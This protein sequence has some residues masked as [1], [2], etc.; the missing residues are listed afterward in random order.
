MVNQKN[1][2]FKN[3]KLKLELYSYTVKESIIVI[4]KFKVKNYSN[5]NF[6]LNAGF[7]AKKFEQFNKIQ[8]KKL[9]HCHHGQILKRQYQFLQAKAFQFY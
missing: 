1:Y 7:K 4:K 6:D 3:F 5:F 2:S 8:R 9:H